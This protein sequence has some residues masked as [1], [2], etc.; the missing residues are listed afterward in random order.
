MS[1]MDEV[2]DCMFTRPFAEDDAL[3]N[4]FVDELVHKLSWEIFRHQ[5]EFCYN[6]SEKNPPMLK[7]GAIEKMI[8]V[9]NCK[10][11]YLRNY[12]I[13][14]MLISY[15]MS[16]VDLGPDCGWYLREE[17]TDEEW[18]QFNKAMNKYV[19]DDYC[20]HIG[21]E[22]AKAYFKRIDRPEFIMEDD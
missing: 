3:L 8:N 14:R 19:W 22:S 15:R 13:C 21:P 12:I 11:G 6:I 1:K 7:D 10:L 9:L 20:K 17:F 2:F 4:D 5:D 18:D 16:N